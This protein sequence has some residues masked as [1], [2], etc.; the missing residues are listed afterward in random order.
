VILPV[1]DVDAAGFWSA[2]ED[3]TLLVAVCDACG[4]HWLPPLATCPR[5]A[6]RAVTSAPAPPAGALYSWTVIHRAADPVYAA[7]TPYTV[8]LVELDD[9]A[10]LYGRVVGVEHDDLR[11]GLRLAVRV[12]RVD[13]RPI[14]EFGPE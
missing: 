5:C 3:G 14:W 4:H 11:D 2:L 1:G 10:R 8:G 7:E 12:A 9:G 13:G 6:S